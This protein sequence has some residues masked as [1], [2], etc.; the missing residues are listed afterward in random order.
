QHEL[1][2]QTILGH[3]NLTE[4]LAMTGEHDAAAVH[5]EA[6]SRL[7][8]QRGDREHELAGQFYLAWLRYWLG[9]WE[10]VHSIRH[11]PATVHAFGCA[12]E[13]MRVHVYALQG[14]VQSAEEVFNLANNK[15]VSEHA[16]H[17][18]NAEAAE[19]RLMLSRGHHGKALVLGETAFRSIEHTWTS[20][21]VQE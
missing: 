6:A 3:I 2:D 12:A 8:R 15:L 19:A 7:A 18:A 20:V 1:A 16:M 13:L 21:G 4:F 11:N 5:A 14:A 9:D 10:A 17:K